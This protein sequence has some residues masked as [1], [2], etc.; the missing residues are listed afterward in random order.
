MRWDPINPAPPVIRFFKFEIKLHKNISQI[1]FFLKLGL[2][3]YNFLKGV[4]GYIF[5]F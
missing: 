2:V 5:L 4:D 3:K 1:N